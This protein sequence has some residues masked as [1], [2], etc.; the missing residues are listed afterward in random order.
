VIVVTIFFVVAWVVFT[1]A[2][3]VWVG[4]CL[5]TGKLHEDRE[6]VEQQRAALDAEWQ[7]LDQTRRVRSVFLTTRRAMQTEAERAARL[8]AEREDE[9]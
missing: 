4:Y 5:A 7:Q 3:L 2:A 8:F 6:A 1:A 9:R